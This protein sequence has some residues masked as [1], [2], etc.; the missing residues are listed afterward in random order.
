MLRA[1]LPMSRSDGGPFGEFERVTVETAIASVEE[2][3]ARTAARQELLDGWRTFLLKAD[4]S[5][6]APEHSPS[7]VI[8]FAARFAKF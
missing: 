2:R 8:C 7:S 5:P 3:P 6:A 4:L 1:A